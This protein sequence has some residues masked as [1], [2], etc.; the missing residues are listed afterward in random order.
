MPVQE[1]ER[2][3]LRYGARIFR[4]LH[5]W[6]HRPHIAR[7]PLERLLLGGESAC[8]AAH[9]ARLTGDIMRPS[10]SI[11]RSPHVRLLQEYEERGARILEPDELR[12]TAYLE[13]ALLCVEIF[14]RY[15]DARDEAGVR[16]FAAEF[17]ARYEGR[18]APGSPRLGQSTPGS[19]V[20][21]RRIVDSDC[22]EMIDGHH[23]TAIAQMRGEEHLTAQVEGPPVQTPLQSLV[24]DANFPAGRREL[25]QPIDAPDVGWWPVSAPCREQLESMTGFL[26]GEGLI[27][28]RHSSYLDIGARYG[29]FVMQFA[30]RGF[31]ARGVERNPA[32]RAVGLAAYGL[33]P[34]SITRSDPVRYLN[35]NRMVHDVVSCLGVLDGY[36]AGEGSVSAEDFV[37]LLDSRTG[38]VLFLGGGLRDGA[39]PGAGVPGAGALEEWVR[40]HTTFSRITRL[41]ADTAPPAAVGRWGTLLV[42]AR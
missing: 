39:A 4:S 6:Y 14:G 13:N 24:L 28:A 2:R 15:F 12:R 17:I 20:R 23:R 26:R 9:F 21:V 34:E 38:K 42:C 10:T 29:W 32:A 37:R 22:F 19:P 35:S 7:L 33:R 36:L 18:P 40:H 1:L 11:T 5:G 31:A 27:P 3:V 16:D 41:D 25:M 8:S 30:E